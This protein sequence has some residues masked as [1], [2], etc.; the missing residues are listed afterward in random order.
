MS[1]YFLPISMYPA[2]D[3]TSQRHISHLDKRCRFTDHV[4]YEVF[5]EY[6]QYLMMSAELEINN[7]NQYICQR[8]LLAKVLNS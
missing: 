5:I 7:A 8:E 2:F 1:F 4:T 3:K 6:V